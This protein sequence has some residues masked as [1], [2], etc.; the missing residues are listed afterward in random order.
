MCFRSFVVNHFLSSLP[1]LLLLLPAQ[2][3]V[4]LAC[5]VALSCLLRVVTHCKK[6][7]TFWTCF[8]FCLNISFRVC[9]SDEVKWRAQMGAWRYGIIKVFYFKFKVVTWQ[10]WA[11][12][13]GHARQPNPRPYVFRECPKSCFYFHKLKDTEQLSP[14]QI[15]MRPWVTLVRERIIFFD[16]TYLSEKRKTDAEQET[17]ISQTEVTTT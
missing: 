4:M 2:T 12:I 14:Q 17:F 15:I 1:L 6:Q 7:L 13:V 10:P 8:A 16:F 11:A 5:G 9:Y 3:D